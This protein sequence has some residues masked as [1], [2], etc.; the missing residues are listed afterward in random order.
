MRVLQ[1]TTVVALLSA[2]IVSAVR[3]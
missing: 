2:A 3:P 1:A